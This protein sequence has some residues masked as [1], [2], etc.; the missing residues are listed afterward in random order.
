[1][2]LFLVLGAL[3]VVT[4]NSSPVSVGPRALRV[5][6]DISEHSSIIYAP[7]NFNDAGRA[8]PEAN[9]AESDTKRTL[10]L[11]NPLLDII[12]IASRGFLSVLR[13]FGTPSVATAYPAQT[14]SPTS[15]SHKVETATFV[16]PAKSGGDQLEWFESPDWRRR[17]LL[18]MLHPNGDTAVT[19]GTGDGMKNSPEEISEMP[20][21][22][23][24]S[25]SSQHLEAAPT[26][27][28]GQGDEVNRW[29]WYYAP[30]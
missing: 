29:G 6:R 17:S 30:W 19:S 1:M 21:E 5:I 12:R 15:S 24:S 10:S 26:Q 13:N 11:T 27:T 8:S 9:S 23:I 20:T 28:V 4:V 22:A 2:R 3:A 25:S 18:D 16:P 14:A 7:V